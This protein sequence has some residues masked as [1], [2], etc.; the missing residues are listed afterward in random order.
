MEGWLEGVIGTISPIAL[1]LVAGSTFLAGFLR[2]FV[3][4]GGALVVIMVLSAVLGPLA[5]VAVA[6]L[7]GLPSMMQLLPNA[8]RFS[9]RAFTIPFGLATFV[10]APFGTLIL[11][12]IAPELMRMAISSFVLAMVAMLYWDWRPRRTP[13]W[14]AMLGA[15]ATAGLVQGSAGI[16]GPPAVV[17]ALSRPG[18]AQQQR[19][20][21][22]GAVA[23]LN[24]CSLIPL[25]YHDLF[26][27]QVIIVSLMLIPLY[28]LATWFGARYFSRGG[29]KHYRIAA[30][31]T[32]AA[33]GVVT[34]LLA[35]QD[36][37]GN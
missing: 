14:I 31:L 26:T 21:V 7:T 10:A 22:L 32:L 19:A 5:A 12:S 34:L 16:G 2:G 36:F 27:L 35:I 8:F 9:D 30:L 20:N 4:F 1:A 17:V 18:E 29:H 11:V 6:A 37:V 15:G 23:S 3:G 28:S 24:L 25:W 13:G 33:I